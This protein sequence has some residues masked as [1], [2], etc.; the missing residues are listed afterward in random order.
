M[1]EIVAFNRKIDFK[2]ARYVK[3]FKVNEV[4]KFIIDNDLQEFF[5]LEEKKQHS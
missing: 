5:Y 1:T 3:N 4:K 2:K